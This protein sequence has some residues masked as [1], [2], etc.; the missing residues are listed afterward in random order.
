VGQVRHVP[1]AG[2]RRQGCTPG[3]ACASRPG[4]PPVPTGRA[5]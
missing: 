1:S 4:S 5:G 3:R 2:R